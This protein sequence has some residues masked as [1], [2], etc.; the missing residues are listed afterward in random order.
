[1]VKK[2]KEKEEEAEKAKKAAMI[3]AA[4]EFVEATG[5]KILE[6]RGEPQ[7]PWDQFR[8]FWTSVW[9]ED[10]YFGEFEDESE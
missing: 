7:D 10:G 5:R 3:K 4:K 1:M 8:G 2:E 6:K 9:G